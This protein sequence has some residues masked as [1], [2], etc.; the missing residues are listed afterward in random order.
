M[1]AD[2]MSYVLAKTQGEYSKVQSETVIIF[3][4]THSVELPGTNVIGIDIHTQNY[5]VFVMPIG[6]HDTPTKGWIHP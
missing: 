5:K 2:S 3:Y 4:M 6:M 1:K